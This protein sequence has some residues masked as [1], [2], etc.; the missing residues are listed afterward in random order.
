MAMVRPSRIGRAASRRR[1]PARF[2]HVRGWPSL[3]RASAGGHSVVREDET[4]NIPYLPVLH[5]PRPVASRRWAHSRSS[6]RARFPGLPRG[7]RGPPATRCQCRRVGTGPFPFG[8][9][10]VR[11]HCPWARTNREDPRLR[12]RAMVVARTRR[13][14]PLREA[15]TH[16]HRPTPF[17]RAW[18][19]RPAKCM[20]R[21][22]WGQGLARIHQRSPDSWAA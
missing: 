19:G 10:C 2:S 6:S 7:Q 13:D 21:V 1:G 8:A 15:P 9:A 4:P 20:A 3:T 17:P 14:R 16:C 18:V 22:R 5:S 12:T 11:C